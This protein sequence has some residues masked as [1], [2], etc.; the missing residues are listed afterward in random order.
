MVTDLC[1][2]LQGRVID[3]KEIWLRVMAH[4]KAFL[5][6]VVQA[7]AASPAW[8]RL[9]DGLQRMRGGFVMATVLSVGLGVGGGV[10]PAGAA[11]ETA[12]VTVGATV[13]RHISI[14][15]L[16]APRTVNISQADIVHGYVNVAATSKLEIR[17]NSPTGYMLAI[18]SQADF[19]R[20]TEVRGNGGVASLG[21]FGGILNIHTVGHGMQ[22]TPVELSFRIL[23]SEQ[24]RPGVYPWALQ[25]SVL[26]V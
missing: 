26:P 20:G 7:Q 16:T 5:E 18:E 25:I 14:R 10:M 4:V 24:A 19:A 12:R 17:T 3:M 15:V 21:R 2:G 9:A 6:G 1:C 23:L 13:L 8:H 11:S 22:T